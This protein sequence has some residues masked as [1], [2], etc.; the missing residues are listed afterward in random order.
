MPG[1]A[2]VLPVVDL[3]HIGPGVD[4]LPSPHRSASARVVRAGEGGRQRFVGQRVAGHA[5]MVAAGA[6]RRLQLPRE[7]LLLERAGAVAPRTALG[8]EHEAGFV[9]RLQH[10]RGGHA[11]GEPH[12]VEADP[13]VAP[14]GLRAA[15]ELAVRRLETGRL[16][17]AVVLADLAVAVA[18]AE[19]GEA[20]AVDRVV[21]RPLGVLDKPESLRG[22]RATLCPSTHRQV[23]PVQGGL[24]VLAERDVRPPIA[25]RAEPK[26]SAPASFAV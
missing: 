6:D 11:G 16:G 15:F 17:P 12:R 18:V 2:P 20:D 26:E 4:P 7:V 14:P 13:L 9:G 21:V 5:G 23:Q 3:E 19:A 8:H 24:V 1:T 22:V 10:V 25:L